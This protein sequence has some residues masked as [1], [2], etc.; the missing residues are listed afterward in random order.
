MAN[1]TLKAMRGWSQYNK[2][3]KIF[4]EEI[5]EGIISHTNLNPSC[6]S[7]DAVT[8]LNPESNQKEVIL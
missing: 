3:T 8:V 1:V 6:V 7:S 4:R 2:I 5:V